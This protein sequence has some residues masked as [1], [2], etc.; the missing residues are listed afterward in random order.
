MQPFTLRFSNSQLAPNPLK[1]KSERSGSENSSDSVP[2]R[3]ISRK[4]NGV[5]TPSPA[6]SSSSGRQP[7]SV[8]IP[9]PSIEQRKE[10]ESAELIKVEPTGISQEYF[11]TNAYEEKADKGAY[12]AARKVNR[13]STF[14]AIRPLPQAIST[15]TSINARLVATLRSKLSVIDGPKVSVVPKDELALALAVENFQ[16]V[17]SYQLRTGVKLAPESFNSGCTCD[18]FCDPARCSCLELSDEQEHKIIPYRRS[19]DDPRTMLLSEKFLN[20]KWMIME[21]NS[22]CGC[23]GNCWNAVT[24]GRK[25]RLEI[26]HTGNRGFGKAYPFSS[27]QT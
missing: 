14:L 12:P 25:V 27:Y 10:I 13:S 6:A 16:F 3:F 23:K 19:P 21:C 18:A 5:H 15:H 8:V 1:R 2:K 7:I 17:N 24:R 4:I 26:F 11:P 9:S 20:I 22:R